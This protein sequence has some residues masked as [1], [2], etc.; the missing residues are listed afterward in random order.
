MRS[1]EEEQAGSRKP[2]DG[3]R[4]LDG[5][6]SGWALEKDVSGRSVV[7]CLW[8]SSSRGRVSGEVVRAADKGGWGWDGFGGRGR[9]SEPGAAVELGDRAS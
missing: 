3:N 2:T 9:G 7:G 6:C 4:A 1:E 8:A 5:R